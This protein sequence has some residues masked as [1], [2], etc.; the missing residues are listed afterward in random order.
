[1]RERHD[2]VS[3]KDD[4]LAKWLQARQS[5]IRIFPEAAKDEQARNSMEALN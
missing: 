1:M 2:F 5:G 4:D 3:F